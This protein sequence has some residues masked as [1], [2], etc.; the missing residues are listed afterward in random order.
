[1]PLALAISRDESELAL[2]TKW[3]KGC[4]YNFYN[5]TNLTT[6]FIFLSCNSVLFVLGLTWAVRQ[7]NCDVGE[8]KEELENEL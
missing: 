7:V 8:A 4:N 5:F 2:G 3:V 1:M 6:V